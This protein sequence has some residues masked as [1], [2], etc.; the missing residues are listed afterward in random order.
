MERSGTR[1]AADDGDGG[2]PMTATYAAVL[3]VEALVLLALWALG[4]YFGPA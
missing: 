1:A 4:R 2:R 3:A